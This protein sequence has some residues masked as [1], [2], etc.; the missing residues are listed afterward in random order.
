[1]EVKFDYIR[2]GG[3]RKDKHQELM[4]KENLDQLKMELIN[5]LN[6]VNELERIE[7]TLIIPK[8]GFDIKVHLESNIPGNIKDI[9]K[10]E[11]PFNH[12]SLTHNEI[13]KNLLNKIWEPECINPVK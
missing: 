13:A 11:F 9:I 4:L 6:Y 7:L 8:N 2:I 12:R 1:M 10:N 3:F 5:T